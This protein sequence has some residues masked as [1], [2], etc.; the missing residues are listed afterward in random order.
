VDAGKAPVKGA[1][2]GVDYLEEGETLSLA[3]MGEQDAA[4]GVRGWYFKY[5]TTGLHSFGDGYFYISHDGRD[6][7]GWFTNVKLYK[8]DGVKPMILVEE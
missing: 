5:G 2:K 7:N 1:L 4:S 8:W 3:E 6:E